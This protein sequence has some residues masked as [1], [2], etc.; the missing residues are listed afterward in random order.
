MLMISQGYGKIKTK[1]HQKEGNAGIFCNKR[2]AK[3]NLVTNMERKIKRSTSEEEDRKVLK[4]K[5]WE[6][7]N[8]N[9]YGVR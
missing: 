4:G 5:L 3:K 9:G 7:L 1:W 6:Q 2:S 8:M